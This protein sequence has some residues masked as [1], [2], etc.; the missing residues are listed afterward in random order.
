MSHQEAVAGCNEP[1]FFPTPAQWGSRDGITP[2]HHVG[3]FLVLHSG[4]LHY[5]HARLQCSS[6]WKL[7]MQ[8][9]TPVPA[10]EA[11]HTTRHGDCAAG[12][13]Q[14]G[15][16]AEGAVQAVASHPQCELRFTTS[17]PEGDSAAPL[18]LTPSPERPPCSSLEWPC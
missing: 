4:K 6:R 10:V 13:P 14:H 3:P 18:Q 17:Y 15:E 9:I 1:P 16:T 7:H 5:R 11:S 12:T 2:W 8:H